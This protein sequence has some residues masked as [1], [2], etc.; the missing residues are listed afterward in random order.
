MASGIGGSEEKFLETFFQLISQF[1]FDKAKDLS[2]SKFTDYYEQNLILIKGTN[3]CTGTCISKR[4][5]SDSKIS[6]TKL[7][8]LLAI[9][10]GDED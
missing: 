3:T 6:L 1:A 10:G 7:F 9:Q 5:T 8:S 4:G 2:V